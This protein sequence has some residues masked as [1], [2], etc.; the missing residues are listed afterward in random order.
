MQ[1]VIQQSIESTHNK[2]EAIL[3]NLNEDSRAALDKNNGVFIVDAGYAD[4]MAMIFNGEAAHAFSER[5]PF[6]WATKIEAT[7]GAQAQRGIVNA[8]IAPGTK[9]AVVL[10][11]VLNA[12]GVPADRALARA[13]RGDF[14][15]HV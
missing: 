10:K 1:F 11:T 8:S 15:G 13:E 12:I 7:D 5:Q 14:D 6:G 9:V 3:W 2:A 4:T